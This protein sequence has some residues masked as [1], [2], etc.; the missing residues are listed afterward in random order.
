MAMVFATWQ[1]LLNNFVVEVAQFD[2]AQIG[3]LQS[4]RE[5]PGFLA[6]TAVFVLLVMREQTMILV[7]LALMCIGVSLTGYFPSELGLYATTVVMSVGFHYYETI[8]QSL[9]LQWLPKDKTAEFMGKSLSVKAAGSLL[10]YGVIYAG[11]SWLELDYQWIYLLTG[12]SGLALVAYLVWSVPMFQQGPIQHKHLFLRK[13]YW[14]Y[15]GL[16]F[17][18]GA[19][20][21]IFVVFAGFLMVEKFGFTVTDITALFVINYLFNLTCAPAIGRLIK[22]IGDRRALIVEYV[23][24]ILVFIGYGLADQAWQAGTLYV[25]DHL[26]FALAI[27]L[28][29]YLQKIA[30]PQDMAAT[31]SVSFTINH[32]A[33]VVIPALLGLV[34]LTDH[35]LVFFVGAGFALLSLLLCLAV[36]VSPSPQ[37]PYLKPL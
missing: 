23:G 4:L 36:P 2:G 3:M 15:Y 32:I 27:A 25:I 31:A 19:R 29:S 13:N 11:M 34:W 20:R 30:D 14:L 33:A 7:S 12:L 37:Q 17:L 18:S 21:Q 28:K 35:G 24:L 22:H 9:T 6:F 16:T 26:L 1:T 10:A 5:V 8:N